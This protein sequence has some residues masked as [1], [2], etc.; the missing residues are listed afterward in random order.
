MD[1]LLQSWV[2]Q[3]AEVRPT[4]VAIVSGAD[5]LTYGQL[6]ITSNQLARL[7]QDAGCQNGDRVCILMPKSAEAI[8]SM[9]GILKAG[10]MHVP[11]DVA[12]PAAR[13]R[14]IFDSCENRV[15]VAGGRVVPLL[16]ELMADE[17]LR[18]RTTIIWLEN[19]GA[20]SAAAVP[21]AKNFKVAFSTR[22]LKSAPST[23]LPQNRVANDGSHILFTSGSTGVPKGVVITHSNVSAFVGW[24][25]K[26]YGIDHTDRFSGHTPFHFDLSTF[27]IFGSITAGAQ[28]HL[29]PSETAL[30]PPKLAEFIRTSKLT[31]WFS[32][33]SVLNY[34]AKFNSVQQNDFPDLRRVLWCGEVLPTPA[35]IYWMER[36]PKVHF[37]NLYG[38]TEATIASSYYD[39]TTCPTDPKSQIPIGTPCDGEDLLVLNEKLEAIPV[40]E[41][42]DLYITGAGLSPGYWRD[43]AKTAA[44][45][46]QDP[47][48]P[49]RRLYRTGDL[50]Y[51]DEQGLVWFVG[52]ADTQIKVRG[53][54]IEL[55]EIETALNSMS[56][57]QEC[58]VVAIPTDNFGGYMICAA[59]VVRAGEQATLADL[60]EHL[61]KLVPN[62]MMPARWTACEAL[63]KN[64]N[65]KIDRPRLKD[66]F[67]RNET[68]GQ[69]ESS[70]GAQAT[71]STSSSTP[72]SSSESSFPHGDR[73]SQV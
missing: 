2:T 9:I 63:P 66:A 54:R 42:G 70:S 49:T 25:L 27:D 73:G 14:H 48:D 1:R 24:A 28:L 31:Q 38:P 22:D 17:A 37:S 59:Y 10:C 58:A 12:T 6:E 69:T 34:M 16:D 71:S 44:A 13:I 60:R 15:I 53:Y 35:L 29:V 33:P 20:A 67:A 50:A 26:H 30:L 61:K 43:P 52:R 8:V 41:I 36:L 72:K 55:G 56:K 57:L 39:V 64:A 65:G 32:V 46:L 7:L 40:R 3:Q 18:S 21:E 68:D 45:F 51:R 47:K 11:I 23:P 19:L 62:Y 5:S 4:D